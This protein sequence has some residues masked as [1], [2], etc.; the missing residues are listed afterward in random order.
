MSKLDE[1]RKEIKELEDTLN[2][3]KRELSETIAKEEIDKLLVY[4]GSCCKISSRYCTAYLINVSEI[5]IDDYDPDLIDISADKVVV[6][7]KDVPGVNLD[8]DL[9]IYDPERDVVEKIDEDKIW[10]SIGL[11]IKEICLG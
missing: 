6:I 2:D 8:E 7:D 5:E 11:V 3:K 10:E 9:F 4:Q 1:L